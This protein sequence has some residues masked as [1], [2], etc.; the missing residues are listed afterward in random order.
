MGEPQ[1]SRK[2]HYLLE[3]PSPYNCTER[4]NTAC[5]FFNS[6]PNHYLYLNNNNNKQASKTEQKSFCAYSYFSGVAN[7][8]SVM[9]VLIRFLNF[10]SE[11]EDILDMFGSLVLF[12]ALSS[13]PAA[14][15]LCLHCLQL[16]CLHPI[17]V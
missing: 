15:R 9:Y 6:G 14:L 17:A 5:I 8:R 2:G 16:S 11:E 13:E 10:H 3:K 4:L 12:S 1:L 7:Y